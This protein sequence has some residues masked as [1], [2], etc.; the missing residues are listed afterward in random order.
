VSNANR[1]ARFFGGPADIDKQDR[2]ERLFE[3]GATIGGSAPNRN[4]SSSS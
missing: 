2:G 4:I 1:A 3:L